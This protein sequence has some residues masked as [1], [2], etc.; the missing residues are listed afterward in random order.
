MV[1]KNFEYIV[2][3]IET[4]GLDLR[5]SSIIEVGAILISN[6]KIKDTFS[7]FIRCEGKIPE[8]IKYITGITD[9]MIKSAP[10]L[11]EVIAR[12]KDFIDKRPVV[13]HNGFSF[14]FPMLESRGLKLNEKYDSLEFSFFVLPCNV[15]G[16]SMAALTQYFGIK[17]VPHRALGDCEIEFQIIC[18]LQKEYAK[19]ENKKRETLNFYAEA[20]EW[21]WFNFL[22]GK[23]S[24]TDNIS[25]LV[26]K[27]EP[28]R[29]E[30]VSQ[31]M[32]VPDTKNSIDLTELDKYFISSSL[33]QA[34]NS[35]MDYS[36]DRPEQKKMASI[37]ANAFNNHKHVVIEAGTGTGK[38]KAYLTP[39]LLFALKNQIPIIIST[40]TKA[41]QDQL[42]IKEIPH[43][44]EIINPD[45]RVAML[46]GKKNYVCLQKFKEFSKEVEE[47]LTQRSL[48]EFGQITTGFSTRLAHLL[49]ASWIIE[50]ERGDWDEL[51]YWFKE[52]IAKRIERDICNI[53][54]LCDHGTCEFYEQQKCFLMKARSRAKDADIVVVNHALTLS[55]II[56]EKKPTIVGEE[57]TGE[58]TKAYSHTVFPNEAKFLVFDEAH[59]LEDDAT[60]AFEQI[61]S[62]KVFQYIFQQLYGKSGIEFYLNRAAKEN[63]RLTT[64]FDKFVKKEHD[65][66]VNT[67]NLFKV[68]LPQVVR[69]NDSDGYS[70]HSML[71]EI[72]TSLKG[73]VV[74]CLENIRIN[75]R[76]IAIIIDAFAEEIDFPRTKKNLQV[77]V[78][79]IK[80]V[81]ASIDIVLD[82][83]KEYVK[84][85][86]RIG[87]DVEIL[88]APLSV[89]K[90]L[91]EYV[92]DNFDSVVMTS[93]TLTVNK[94]FDFFANR[95]GTSLIEK[96][97]IGYHL[98]KSSFN[99]EKQVKFFIP[100]GI[101][102]SEGKDLHIGKSAEFLEK[103]IFASNGGALILCT[104]HKQVDSLY[105]LLEEPLSKKN[106]CLFRQSPGVSV[107]SVV[108]D[109]KKDINSALIGTESLWQGIDVPGIS[110]RSLFIC[111]IP[112]RQLS[113][114]I[115]ARRQEVEDSGGNGFS[116]YY[117]PLAALMLKQGFGR[118]IRKRTDS[119][120]AILLDED[121]LNRPRLLNSLPEGVYPMRVEPE[122]IYN[123]FHKFAE[124]IILG[125]NETI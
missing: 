53:D 120:I 38:S 107:G 51:P 122:E 72:S 41:L 26:S 65:I 102:Y 109:F 61:I 49:L 4:T 117:E 75:L 123:E 11:P 34:P 64:L 17:D 94:E 93:A 24:K 91:K 73:A 70:T 47:E 108:R 80:G 71:E 5:H 33:P 58:V 31:G 13:A 89:A 106:I 8:P 85:F 1:K 103:A 32:L 48:Y 20:I 35:E 22:T 3:D 92:Y 45:L 52:K 90:H 95:C 112:Y 125:K 100:K 99:Y 118:L 69:E 63:E 55:G 43:L 101:S 96:E 86:K 110:L 14:D 60:S 116:D 39:S 25:D 83:S 9:E 78:K 29:K 56:L 105:G 115:K 66:Q 97:G 82:D 37:V 113:P 79:I 67:S 10:N 44:K 54:E 30:N 114:L 74:T 88:A 7:S 59:H 57:S 121:L 98:L 50:T 16:H 19:K 42:F 111:K 27:Y 2:I 68:V 15:G 119:G 12:L 23:S 18:E 76:D 77:K 6:N 87:N 104:S 36:E 81:I 46:K 28:Y 21:W 62:D 40:H 84:Y 124:G